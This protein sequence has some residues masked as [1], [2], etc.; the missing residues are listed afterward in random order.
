MQRVARLIA[1]RAA[2][3]VEKPE[4]AIGGNERVLNDHAARAG[5]LHSDDVPVVDD[6]ELSAIE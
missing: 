2:L 3:P 5:A 4:R 6:L 1:N